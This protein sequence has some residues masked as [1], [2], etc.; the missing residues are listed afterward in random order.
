M[1][2]TT[3]QNS[4]TTNLAP[5]FLLPFRNCTLW[6]NTTSNNLEY[7][8]LQ[9]NDNYV[10]DS[11]D[12][13]PGSLEIITLSDRVIPPTLSF[14]NSYGVVGLYIS[15]VLVLGKFLR[16]SVDNL[17]HKIMFQDLPQVEAIHNICQIILLARE[18]TPP[19]L[20]LEE[21]LYRLLVDI[22]RNPEVITKWTSADLV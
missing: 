3:S 18:S 16:L 2:L 22:Y 11:T 10:L 6:K 12:V 21:D 20:A 15:V 17:S 5:G 1:H 4:D 19:D 9:Q 8:T 13:P 7:W 14:L